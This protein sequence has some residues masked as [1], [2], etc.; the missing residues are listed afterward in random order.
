VRTGAER[1]RIEKHFSASCVCPLFGRRRA[2]EP[3]PE[4]LAPRPRAPLHPDH[5]PL[6]PCA[7]RPRRYNERAPNSDATR[8]PMP[9]SVASHAHHRPLRFSSLVLSMQNGNGVGSAKREPSSVAPRSLG[10]IAVSMHRTAGN[11]ANAN[12]GGGSSSTCPSLATKPTLR[13]VLVVSAMCDGDA[14]R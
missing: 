10:R 2:I 5:C 14:S 3:S 11:P 7:H 12:G 8:P 6:H 4:K 13:H 1:A 9:R